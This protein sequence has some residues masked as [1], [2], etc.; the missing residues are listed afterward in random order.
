MSTYARCENYLDDE[1]KN[2]VWRVQPT[3]LIDILVCIPHHTGIHKSNFKD[4]IATKFLIFLLNLFIER[5]LLI[6]L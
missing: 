3:G 1:F 6:Q 2:Q 5:H 4:I